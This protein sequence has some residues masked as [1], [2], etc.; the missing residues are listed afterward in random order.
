MYHW[1]PF[2]V[3]YSKNSRNYRVRIVAILPVY[4]TESEYISRHLPAYSSHLLLL[5]LF[6]G[7]RWRRWRRWSATATAVFFAFYCIVRYCAYFLFVV[8]LRSIILL[9]V[10]TKNDTPALSAP[11][12]IAIPKGGHNH[13][14]GGISRRGDLLGAGM[15]RVDYKPRPPRDSEL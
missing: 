5:V 12:F 9:Y 11:E 6:R 15:A 13:P 4:T 10:Y 14:K 1:I 2:A 3:F 7:R 8:T